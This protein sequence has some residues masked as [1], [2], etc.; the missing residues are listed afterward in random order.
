VKILILSDVNSV[1]TYRWAKSIKD[2]GNNIEIFSLYKDEN[3]FYPSYKSLG[4]NVTTSNVNKFILY[5]YR[6][7]ITK[8]FYFFALKK[9]KKTIKKF[10]PELLHAHYLSSY[11][12]LANL[13]GFRPYCISIWGDDIFL[14]TKNFIFKK[15]LLS[16]LKN[17]K[18]LF[19]TSKVIDKL[20]HSQYDLSTT[21]IPFG[22]DTKFFKPLNRKKNNPIIIGIIKSIEQHNGIEFLIEAFNIL[23]KKKINNIQ[24]NIVGVGSLEN[25]LKKMVK[26][27]DLENE[28][29]FFG[30]VSHQNIVPHYQKLSIFVCPSLRESFGVSVIEASATA[31]PVIANKIGGLKEVVQDG[32]TGYLLDVTKPEKVADCLEKLIVDHNLRFNLGNNGRDFVKENFSW[33]DNVTKM[34]NAY[35]KTTNFFDIE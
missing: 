33:D 23:I 28:V 12:I 34:L 5:K 10:N 18:Q 7:N 32:K 2:R 19:S 20:V 1:H 11:G 25:K 29:N 6:R 3:K 21:I 4:I 22:V 35:K 26:A 14:P 9:L 16:S 17:A 15:L 8:I 24:L 31:V 13:T 27:Y 30:Y